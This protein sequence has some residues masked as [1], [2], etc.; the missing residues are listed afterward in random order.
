MPETLE[1]D[2]LIDVDTLRLNLGDAGWR[3]VD[4]RH[5]LLQPD[6]GRQAYLQ[7]HIAGAVFAH[8]D[9]DLSGP[10]AADSGRHPLPDPDRLSECFRCWGID[11]DTQIIAYDAN[12]GSYAG[13]LWWLARWL[14]HK[15]VA[16]LDGG[17]QA[18]LKAGLG[19]DTGEARHPPGRFSRGTA[20][21]Q[22][23]GVEA[24]QAART[25]PGWLILDARAPDRYAGQNEV[26]DPV[27][28]HIPGAL[29]RFWQS[30]LQ[31]DG[32]FKSPERLRAEFE[33]LLGGRSAER[34]I[35]QCGSGVTA[36]HG[37]APVPR[38]VERVDHGPRPP[39]RH[40]PRS[41]SLGQRSECLSVRE[42]RAIRL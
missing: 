19:T 14:G 24:V 36:Y 2:T 21:E 25:D 13:R 28:G 29:N 15:R 41:G 16:V 31:S 40:R 35:M 38:L 42:Q 12:S 32:R 39:H 11:P 1:F 10:K 33:T 4:C 34:A 8:L 22:P 18:A 5:D 37:G 23:I 9:Q 26:I 30:N 3:L 27:A 20:R 6:A 17:W 7:G